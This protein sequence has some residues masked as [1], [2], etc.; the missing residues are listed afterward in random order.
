MNREGIEIED[1]LIDSSSS[2]SIQYKI[3]NHLKFF[4]IKLPPIILCEFFLSRSDLIYDEVNDRLGTIFFQYI[5]FTIS[6][7]YL[8]ICLFCCFLLFTLKPVYVF[9][10][11]EVVLLVLQPFLFTYFM[12]MCDDTHCSLN[13]LNVNRIFFACLIHTFT[14]TM[15]I[16]LYNDIY[17]NVIRDKHSIYKRYLSHRNE[18]VHTINDYLN[19][20]SKDELR[21]M[22][23]QQQQQ[24][25][26]L[27][28]KSFL[29][30]RSCFIAFYSTLAYL[31][32][33][34]GLFDH[35]LEK[36]PTEYFNI[37][38]LGYLLMLTFDLSINA[39]Q[40]AMRLLVKIR[41]LTQLF[42]EYGLNNM[43]GFNWF[44]KSRLPYLLRCYFGI[45]CVMF[46]FKFFVYYEHYF[47]LN[48]Q[49]KSDTSVE[50]FSLFAKIYSYFIEMPEIKTNNETSNV[51]G[52][53]SIFGLN[54][55][56]V[57]ET[58]STLSINNKIERIIWNDLKTN[59]EALN[60]I[61][62][63]LKMLLL[64]S[65]Q[66]LIS[67]AS[68]TSLIS[69]Q[70]RLIGLFINKLLN[71]SNNLQQ[72]N[73][74]VV[75]NENDFSNVGD[76]SAILFFLLCIQSGM[77][78]LN[79]KHRVEKF[80]K[81]YSLLFIA[82]LHYFH[83]SLDAQLMTLIASS[84]PDWNSAKHL[85]LLGVCVSLI[86]LPLVILII[87]FYYFSMSTWLLAASAFN[88]E[89]IVKM[90]VSLS[91]YAIFIIDSIRIANAQKKLFGMVKKTDDSDANNNNN[92]NNNIDELTDNTEDY[93]YYIKAFGHVVE[94]FVALVLFFNGA[95][96]LLFESY[97]A[98]RAIMMTIHAYFHI[99]CQ[100][101][102]GWSAFIKRRTAI[103]KMK[104]LPV[105]NLNSFVELTRKKKQ[106][107]NLNH[108]VISDDKN[109]QEIDMENLMRAYEEM[110]S[111][112]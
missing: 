98:I 108:G 63:Y 31:I 81:N 4:L 111:E 23:Q 77:S 17:K 55:V 30:R 36:K 90:S 12:E 100:A 53:E 78:S 80:L 51:I 82:I 97:G 45:K 58:T 46:T 79:G 52:Y 1:T 109:S 75:L 20:L 9:R 47:Y 11:Y 65:T 21:N 56:K 73:V 103:S 32:N 99:W 110:K 94:F 64:N 48:E 89:L 6:K 86:V 106:M 62:L 95:Y 50:N 61:L 70:F 27:D 18:R 87:M 102:K 83:T 44:I 38:S 41:I 85:R 54:T 76:V 60:T 28:D 33:D 59:E 24:Q 8:V 26:Q 57:N 5:I 74:R 72:N 42:D 2:S 22:E 104:C 39:D 10:I 43:L 25:S 101:R 14:A 3:L 107:N 71:A 37:I 34:L 35:M 13:V 15:T 19:T 91:T 93:I 88:I 67:I 84:K 49:I 16:L 68:L 96:I 29:N 7:L 92:N 69:Y 105:F 66:T 112:S 40:L